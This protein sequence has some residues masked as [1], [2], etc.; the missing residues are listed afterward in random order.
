MVKYNSM[1]GISLIFYGDTEDGTFVLNFLSCYK[2][3]YKQ[4]PCMPNK[5]NDSFFLTMCTNLEK[6]V[7]VKT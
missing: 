1:Y 2:F 4:N 6:V 3:S 7:Q 5:K